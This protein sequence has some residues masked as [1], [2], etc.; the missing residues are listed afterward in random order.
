MPTGW[1]TPALHIEWWPLFIA[2][3]FLGTLAATTCRGARLAADTEG[4]V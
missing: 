3:L 1:L 4:L 2:V